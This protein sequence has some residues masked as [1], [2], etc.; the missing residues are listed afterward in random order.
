VLFISPNPAIMGLSLSR[1]AARALVS[2]CIAATGLLSTL[3]AQSLPPYAPMNPLAY[4][5]SG[6][7]TVPYRD[8]GPGWRVSV[9]TDYANLIELASTSAGQ[10]VID[11][12]LMRTELTVSR[13]IGKRTF[14]FGGA[15]L[16]GAYDGFLDGFL[17]WYHDLTGLQVAGRDLRPKNQYLYELE[18]AGGLRVSRPNPGEWLGDVRLGAGYRFTRHWQMAAWATVPTSDG[19]AGFRRGV[20]TANA[21]A[22]VRAH[23]ARRFTYEGTLGFG[24]SARHGEL[25]I[26]ER[27]T[28]A[29][30]SAGVRA[31]LAGPLHLYS[32]I[33]YH[34]PYYR[35]SGIRAVDRR[36]LTIDVGGIFKFRRGPEWIVGLTEDLEPSG[37]AIDVAFRLGARW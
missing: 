6:L 17:E 26:L 34:S 9:L 11:A 22:T 16:N 8:P 2:L 10:L 30:V 18:L 5:R 27:T 4:G 19:P 14:L 20:L 7:E 33:V 37:P 31:R 15:G 36:D 24:W 35:D 23:F 13:D 1:R 25:E 29:Q 28:F 32:N 12:E 3:P 21:I